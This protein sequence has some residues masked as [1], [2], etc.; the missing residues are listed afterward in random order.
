MQH[1]NTTHTLTTCSKQP[2]P[3]VHI[4]NRLLHSMIA[5]LVIVANPH[6]LRTKSSSSTR[7]EAT[8]YLISFFHR[9]HSS[10]VK[11]TR[12]I[13]ITHFLT[14]SLSHF[15]PPVQRRLNDILTPPLLLRS[16]VLNCD[17][18]YLSTFSTFATLSL[19]FR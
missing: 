13:H 12:T 19:L 7:S 2:T 5:M 10:S 1:H 8:M 9:C 4:T 6:H 15:G 11:N 17:S 18:P 3:D 14:H 16:V